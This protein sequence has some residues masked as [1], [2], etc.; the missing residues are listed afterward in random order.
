M[1]WNRIYFAMKA[2]SLELLNNSPLWKPFLELLNS[3]NIYYMS[4]KLTLFFTEGVA[5]L[6]DNGWDETFVI[7]LFISND[8]CIASTFYAT[9]KSALQVVFYYAEKHVT[10]QSIIPDHWSR[11]THTLGIGI[12]RRL[13]CAC[14]KSKQRS[15]K[16]T[17]TRKENIYLADAYTEVRRFNSH[18][19]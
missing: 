10:F 11:S 8:Q 15:N 12:K 2:V 7:H 17:T 6:L 18:F 4:P 14:I 5:T 19:T 1:R 9:E 16:N 13:A 3:K